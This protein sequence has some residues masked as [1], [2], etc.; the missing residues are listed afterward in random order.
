MC[1]MMNAD[2]VSATSGSILSSPRPPVTS[3]TIK[4]P[5]SIA[6]HATFAFD[7]SIEMGTSSFRRK[8]SITGITRRSSSSAVTGSAPGRADSPP[9]SI[10]RAPSAAICKP[11]FV[12][13]FAVRNSPPSENESGVTFNTP[14]INPCRETSKTRLPIFQ[15]LSRIRS[16][17]NADPRLFELLAARPCEGR[18][19]LRFGGRKPPLRLF[20]SCVASDELALCDDVTFH[21]G[22]HLAPLCTR[23]QIQFAIES[24]NLERIAMCAWRRTRTLVTLFA[25]IV[26]ALHA[27]WCTAF[28][29]CIGLWRDVPDQPMSKQSARR[30]RIIGNQDETFRF[31]RNTGYLQRRAGVRP[32]TCE[33]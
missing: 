4:A 11:R 18:R 25:E 22:I 19:D 21:R 14:M 17:T 26:C 6:A 2:L 16:Q 31:G 23:P 1:M 10:M 9:T 30:I 32:V 20:F 13:L 29:N 28:H 24:E 7:V 12:A 27:F 15:V 33:F 3:F 5:A 8:F